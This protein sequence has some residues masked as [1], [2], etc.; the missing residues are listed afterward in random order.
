MLKMTFFTRTLAFTLTLLITISWTSFSQNSADFQLH[1]RNLTLETTDNFNS[2]EM[3][4]SASETE[5]FDGVYFRII[6]FNQIPTESELRQ[7][8][9]AGVELLDYIPHFGYFARINAKFQAASLDGIPVRTMLEITRNIKLAPMLYEENYPDYALRPNGKIELIVSVF[10]GTNADVA[11]GHFT[12]SGFEV[13]SKFGLGDFFSVITMIEEIDALAAVPFVNYIEPRYPDPVHDNYTGRTSHRSNAIANDFEAGRHYDGTGVSVMLQD[14]GKIGPHIDFAG[15]IKEQFPSAFGGDHGDHCAGIIGAAG[16]LDPKARG[17]A[18]GA[19]LY[20][21]NAAPNYP[22]FSSIPSHYFNYNI[23][24]TS[25]SY[26]DGCNAGYTSLARSLD[27]QTINYPSLLHVFSA[28][29]N[30]TSNCGYGAGSG[31]GNIT[32]GHKVGKNVITVANLDYL[33]NLNSSSSRG[34]AHDG[35]IKPDISAKGT[36][37]YST[38]PDDE[39]GSKTGTSMSCPG[40]AGVVTQLFDAYRQLNNGS[41]PT[42]GLIKGLVLNTADDLGNPGPDFRFGWGRINA[43]RAAKVLEENRYEEAAITNGQTNTHEFEIPENTGQ[44]RVMI[45]WTDFQAS[46]N[47]NWTLINNL[48]MKITDPQSNEWLPWVLN[49][50]PHP[51]SLNK[52]AKRGT[53]NRNNVEQV[54]INNPE[55]GT[56]TLTVNGT[57]IP[58]GPQTYYVFYE[59]IPAAVTLTY[60]VGGES[61]TPGDAE[62]IRWDAFGADKTFTI[63]L[64]LDGGYTWQMIQQNINPTRRYWEWNVATAITGNA[65]MRITDGETTSYSEP[66]TIIQRPSNLTINWACTDALHLSWN[67]VLGATSYTVW[68][69]GEKYMEPIGTTTINSMIIYDVPSNQTHW[70]SV[71]ANTPDGQSGQRAVA[72]KKN[73]GVFNCNP[74]DAWLTA[75]PSVDWS[76]FQSCLDLQSVGITAEMKNFGIE[77][78]VN[79]EFSFQLNSGETFTESYEGVVEPDSLVRFTFNTTI[80]ISEIGTHILVVTVIYPQDQNLS[81]NTYASTIEVIEGSSILP[82]AMQ[83]F[84]GFSNCV[85]APICELSNCQLGDNWFNLQNNLHDDIDWRTWYGSTNSFNTGPTFDHTTGNNSGKYLFIQSAVVCFFREAVLM[86]PCVDLR[87]AQSPALDFWYHAYGADIGSLHVDIFDGG[88]IINDIAPPVIGNQGDEWKNMV[89]DLSEY[90]GKVIGIRFRGT[91]GGGIAGDLALDDISITETT[92]VNDRQQ[93]TGTLN[94]FPNPSNGMV[95][96]SASETGTSDYFLTIFDLYGRSVYSQPVQTED[97]RLNLSLNLSN[98]SKGIYF[99]QLKSSNKSYQSKLTIQ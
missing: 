86:M 81:N 94:V 69:L 61:L 64:S 91:T 89:I 44:L 39:Y 76:V 74:T 49:H 51:D 33:D 32:G 21:Y 28:G 47:S 79:P 56:Y 99:V 71:S 22:G 14:D 78:I 53:D 34:P 80:D 23:R 60:P 2:P 24:V 6:Q 48:D 15:R 5:V 27:M 50:F 63:E 13:V 20:V 73:P 43:L 87:D 52:P 88:Q 9:A 35:R 46:V 18:F 36:N 57:T 62:V 82:G 83:T 16:N 7:M 42:G 10:D 72:K 59:Y 4:I 3:K 93:I 31:W 95:N 30:G 70:F 11:I 68:K 85:P 41:D 17:N 38:L 37:V 67:G 65:I 12:K 66:F 40:V 29:N 25:T 75:V 19:D 90:V 54:T 8:A 98:L 55:A 96:I 97:G 26:S 92:S 84:D 1:F 77:T 58:Q 45:Y